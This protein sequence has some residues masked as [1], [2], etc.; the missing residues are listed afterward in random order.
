MEAIVDL[1][2]LD[3]N[4]L[5]VLDAVLEAR[6]ITRAARK[7]GL[8][9]SAVSHALARLREALGDELLV[10]GPG[11][12][13]PTER[14][15]AIAEPLRSTL[16]AL[17]RTLASPAPFDAPASNRTFRV[18]A[19]DYAEFV[20]LPPLL[21]RL[22]AEAPGVNLWVTS[23]T[24]EEMNTRL[25]AGEL[26][27]GLG[28]PLGSAAGAGLRERT[29]FG[30]HF[31][32]M[33]RADHPTVGDTLTLDQYVGMPHAFIAPRGRKGG[34]VDTALSELNL[35]RR[36]ALAVPHFLVVP[37]IV[38]GSDLIVTLA[39]RVAHAFALHLPLRILAPPL[40][41]PTF[42]ITVSW[43]NRHQQDPG[44]VW[45]REVLGQIG[46]ALG[47]KDS[48]PVAGGMQNDPG[49]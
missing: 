13:V 27:F 17:E 25:A 10:R 39:A 47:Q 30:E 18:A 12:L 40:T 34:V 24:Q 41:L 21:A 1:R 8:S 3:L 29:L 49:D 19:G 5:G 48:A 14:A 35:E 6:H 11:G 43:H 2:S 22:K 42:Q 38:A 20:L 33:V 45:L 44:H 26:D 9:Q 32:C 36:I 7:L 28:V 31:V 16:A 23:A 15:L 37:H 46:A 4:L